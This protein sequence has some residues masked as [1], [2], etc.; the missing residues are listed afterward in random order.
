MKFVYIPPVITGNLYP[1]NVKSKKCLVCNALFEIKVDRNITCGTICRN[2]YIS[3]KYNNCPKRR[4]KI[5]IAVMG[6]KNHNWKG[7]K[8]GYVALHNW[9]NSRIKRP[10]ICSLCKKIGFIDL[11][12]KSGEY[13]R[14][15]KDWS[16]LCRSCHMKSDGR[17]KNL[18]NVTDCELNPRKN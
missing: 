15:I 13:K 18:K 10:K 3:K 16:W 5:S 17:M 7:N 4:M 6:E 12:N 11:A 1:M 8:V 2:R 14:D 9:I